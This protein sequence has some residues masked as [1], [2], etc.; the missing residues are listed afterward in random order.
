MPNPELKDH[1]RL[2]PVNLPAGQTKKDYNSPWGFTYKAGVWYVEP[3][4][5]AAERAKYLESIHINSSDDYSPKAFNV[6]TREEAQRLKLFEESDQLEQVMAASKPPIPTAP[7]TEAPAAMSQDLNLP[8]PKSELAAA[9]AAAAVE[10]EEA[11]SAP[12]AEESPAP[13]SPPEP[14]PKAA[15][16]PAKKKAQK[17]RARRRNPGR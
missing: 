15:K 8:A 4:A 1:V 10:A 11:R 6:C 16:A 14:K 7:T 9:A 13:S 5:L 2:K 17:P 3:P 12:S